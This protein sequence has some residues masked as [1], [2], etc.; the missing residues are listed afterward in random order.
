VRAKIFGEARIRSL[1]GDC[2]TLWHRVAGVDCQIHQDVARVVRVCFYGSDV[3]ATWISIAMRSPASGRSI[4]STLPIRVFRLITLGLSTWRRLNAARSWRVSEV[5]RSA[6]RKI[7][8]MQRLSA[9]RRNAVH[10]NLAV[11]GDDGQQVVECRGRCRRRA[12][13][14]FHLLGLAKLIFKRLRP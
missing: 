11:T 12:Y 7:C 3:G 2:S 14:G 8:S 13:D 1:D 6:A 5:A 10:E 4:S 9:D